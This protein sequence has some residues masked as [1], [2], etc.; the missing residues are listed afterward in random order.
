MAVDSKEKGRAIPDDDSRMQVEDK[1]E[2]DNEERAEP[3]GVS[4]TSI[5]RR[6]AVKSEPSAVT[7]KEV[8]DGYRE[9]ALRI[10][11]VG[12]IELGS[13][14]DLS[15]TCAQTGKTIQPLRRSVAAQS[16][17]M[18]HEESQSS[19]SRQALAR[20]DAPQRAGCDD[21]RR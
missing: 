10:E 19:D 15:I 2:I 20:E 9:K 21:Q 11:S 18:E 5:R 14:M 1:P 16:G 12:Q 6:I 13:I 8:V 4:W 3:P 7:T 17:W